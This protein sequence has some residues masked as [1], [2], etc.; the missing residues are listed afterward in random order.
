MRLRRHEESIII[1]YYSILREQLG[2]DFDYIGANGAAARYK[3]G[4]CAYRQFPCQVFLDLCRYL[5]DRHVNASASI[6][7]QGERIWSNTDR[8]P[9][10]ETFAQKWMPMTLAQLDT[11]NP[12]AGIER[13]Q[14]FTASD[15]RDS[16]KEILM[17]QNYPVTIT[18]SDRYIIDLG[19][20]N[21]TKGTALKQLC[22]LIGYH[23]M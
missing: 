2:F 14:V 1:V 15:Q 7:W 20:Q 9:C 10:E 23:W 5:R 22:E 18:T 3:D 16:L 4:T 12:N 8:Y 11:L 6:R 19:P 21:C 13:T 17:K